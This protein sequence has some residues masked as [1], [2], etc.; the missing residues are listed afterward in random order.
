MP[1]LPLFGSKRRRKALPKRERVEIN[2]NSSDKDLPRADE[3]IA[4]KV[5]HFG[6]TRIR[7]SSLTGFGSSA[8]KK[9]YTISFDPITPTKP[10]K[11]ISAPQRD[12]LALVPSYP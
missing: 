3:V 11:S 7:S 12:I 4:T 5:P 9:S 2:L 8:T 6:T 1:Y 10:S